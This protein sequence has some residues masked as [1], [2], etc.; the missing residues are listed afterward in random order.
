MAQAAKIVAEKAAP[1]LLAL[2]VD[3]VTREA[4]SR[5]AS[6]L[7]WT[8]VA[9]RAGGLAKAARAIDAAKAPQVLLVDFGD[10]AEPDAALGDLVKRCGPGTRVLAIGTLNDVTLFRRLAA[11]GIADYLLKPVS[12]EILCD[13]LR[14]AVRTEAEASD[15][16]GRARIHAVIGARGGVGASTLAVSLAWLLSKEHS[17]PTA[18]IDLDLH[19]GNVALSLDLEPGRG[20]RQA[21]EHPERTDSLLLASAVVKG[22]ERLPILAAEESLDELLRFEADGANALLTAMA[23]D[24]EHLVVDLPRSLDSA[25]RHVLAAADLTMIVTD[26]SLAALRD[27]FRLKG[28]VK[29]L[30]GSEI[31]VVGNQVGALHRGEI[32]RTEFE[33]GMGGSLDYAVP[34]DPK[35]ARTMA[36][37]GKPLPA[38]EPTSKANIEIRRIA[39]RIAGQEAK[40]KTGWRRW[41]G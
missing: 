38:G 39:A 10:E 31:I 16:K 28:L 23:Q 24:Y 17:L 19:F 6:Q 1:Q 30:G 7:G 34:F 41:L 21:L 33:R 14:R 8:D 18:L 5:A 25:A 13:A 20:L 9:V 29:S 15:A 36:V 27:A 37:S 40:P 2:V 4:V 22:D 35:A 12:S 26:L 3:E 11:R 32:G